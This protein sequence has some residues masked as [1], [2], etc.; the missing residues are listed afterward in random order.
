[1]TYERPRDRRAPDGRG[2]FHRVFDDLCRPRPRVWRA[3]DGQT[4]EVF[5]KDSE[6]CDKRSGVGTAFLSDDVAKL[7]PTVYK[8]CMEARGYV[9]QWAG[10]Q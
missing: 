3:T 10:A 4:S 2:D 6:E 9:F 7:H 8:R 1:V 5:T